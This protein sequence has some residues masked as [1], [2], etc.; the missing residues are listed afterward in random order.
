MLAE[1][2][3]WELQ[4]LKALKMNKLEEA[5]KFIIKAVE[6]EDKTTYDPGPPVVLKPAHEVYGEILLAMN[7]ST[8]AIEQF[9]LSLKRAP[10]RSC[11]CLENTKHSKILERNKR[12]HR[13]KRCS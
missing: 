3:E 12:L 4:A 9:D 11:L 7:N 8:K 13:S 1:V 6:L 10:N 5:E 2:M